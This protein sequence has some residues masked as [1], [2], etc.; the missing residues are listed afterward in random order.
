[1]LLLPL[2]PGGISRLPYVGRAPRFA[3]GSRQRRPG[4]MLLARFE[5]ISLRRTINQLTVRPAGLQGS[6]SV[7]WQQ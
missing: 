5:T 3:K 1:M 7:G 4:T 2:Q 6:A